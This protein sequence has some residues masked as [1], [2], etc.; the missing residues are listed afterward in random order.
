MSNLRLSLPHIVI[1][2]LMRPVCVLIRPK[3]ATYAMTSLLNFRALADRYLPFGFTS[4]YPFTLGGI[5]R[6]A[7]KNSLGGRPAYFPLNSARH[8]WQILVLP[9]H[10]FSKI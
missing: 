6:V 4:Q 3:L 8:I 9:M 1:C 2:A 7:L 5:G 10:I